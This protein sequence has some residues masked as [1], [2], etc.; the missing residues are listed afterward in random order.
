MTFDKEHCIFTIEQIIYED[1]IRKPNIIAARD[2]HDITPN[3]LIRGIN[4]KK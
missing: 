3:I 1:G 2:I 4:I